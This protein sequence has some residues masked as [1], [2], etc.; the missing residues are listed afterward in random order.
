M[1]LRPH[2]EIRCLTFSDFNE[3]YTLVSLSGKRVKSKQNRVVP[4]PDYI[5][6]LILPRAKYSNSDDANIFTLE[7]HSYNESYFKT[8]WGK[9]KRT[10]NLLKENQTLYSFRHTGAIR[11]YEKSGSLATLQ[12]VMGHSDMKV[13]LTYLRGLEVKQLDVEDLPN[14]RD[15]LE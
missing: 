9:Y 2:R 6:Q 14:L 8:L 11:V 3:D 4:V 1:L 13:S 12:R 5:R 10:T 15:D 7:N